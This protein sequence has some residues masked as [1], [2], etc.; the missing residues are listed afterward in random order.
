MIGSVTS[1]KDDEHLRF[2]DTILYDL[3]FGGGIDGG[4]SVRRWPGADTPG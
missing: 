3:A 4:F 2:V 1:G